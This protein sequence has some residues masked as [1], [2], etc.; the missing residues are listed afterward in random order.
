MPYATKETFA[1]QR[2]SCGRAVIVGTEHGPR[3]GI[4]EH[5]AFAGD[6]YIKT[7]EHEAP[8][9]AQR[10][11]TFKECKTE[12]EAN[13]LPEYHWSWPPRV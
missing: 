10:G 9:H 5:I 7:F 12:D 3:A 4:I 1:G 8:P 11:Y 6:V 13:A 2:A